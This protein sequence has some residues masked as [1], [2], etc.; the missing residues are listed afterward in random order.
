PVVSLDFGDAPSADYPTVLADN[1]P[2]HILDTALYMGACIDDE[3]NG[4]QSAN[5]DGDNAGIENAFTN[6]VCATA[7]NDEDSLTPPTFTDGQT[8]PSVIVGVVN[9]TGA[10]AFLAC[11]VDYS[12]TGFELAERS[13]LTIVANNVTSV[14][15]TLPDVPTTASTTTD[16]SSFMRCRLASTATEIENPTGAATNGEIEDYPVTMEIVATALLDFGDAPDSFGTSSAVNGANHILDGV[17]YLGTCVDAEADGQPSDADNGDDLAVSTSVIG[18]CL[19]TTDEDGVQLPVSF[20][21]GQSTNI[22]VT[23][24]AACLLNAWV[25][26]NLDGDWLD[27]GEQVF[28]DQALSA[29]VNNLALNVPGII[30]VGNAHSRFRCSTQGGL[31]P[32]GLAPDGEVEDYFPVVLVNVFDPPSGF[33]TFNAAGLPELVW[34]MIW[35]ND[36]NAVAQRVRV[37]DEISEGTVYIANSLSCTGDGITSVDTCLFEA[38]SANFPRGRVIYEGDIGPDLGAN[39]TTTEEQANNELVILFRTTVNAGV[40][41]VNNQ[42]TAQYDANGDGSVDDEVTGGQSSVLSDDPTQIGSTNINLVPIGTPPPGVPGGS[43]QKI[44]TLSE[45]ARIILIMLIGMTAL[46]QYRRRRKRAVN[47]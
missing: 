40:T 18:S 26:W 10:D 41:Q 12:G 20:V 16:G 37:T 45:W 46:V 7:N 17:T 32:T 4:Q 36:G 24:N 29:G 2:R 11:W 6:G 39:Q 47:F 22:T 14:T 31:T 13:T 25:D 1:G 35:F 30:N 27:L 43:A 3:A 19:D 8:T 44:P 9:T 21:A 28:T 23:A 15:V 38:P 5:A 33:K 42:A 34:K